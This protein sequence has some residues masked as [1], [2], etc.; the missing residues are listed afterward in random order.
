MSPYMS[1]ETR[2]PLANM[3]VRFRDVPICQYH[4]SVSDEKR[5]YSPREF[6]RI[7]QNMALIREFETMISDLKFSGS[8]Q[9]IDYPIKNTIALDIGKEAIS[10][11]EAYCFG[12]NDILFSS[13]K[14]IGD[15]IAKGLSSIAKMTDYEKVRFVTD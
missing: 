12:Q 5:I 15:L 2:R 13:E 3:A 14:S 10:V 7:Y 8:Y 9:G 6:L 11:G 1:M 4:L